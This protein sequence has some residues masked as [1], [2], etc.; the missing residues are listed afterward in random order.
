MRNRG[1]LPLMAIS[2]L[3]IK[4]QDLYVRVS[5]ISQPWGELGAERRRNDV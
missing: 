4:L 1:R 5:F 2:F 3:L